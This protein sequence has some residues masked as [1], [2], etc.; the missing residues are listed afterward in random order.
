MIGMSAHSGRPRMWSSTSSPRQSRHHEVEDDEV[1]ALFPLEYLDRFLSVER[2]R[3][4]EGPLL[5][6]DLDDAANVSFVIGDKDMALFNRRLA[7][8][9]SG[10]KNR[11]YRLSMS[12]DI[13]QQHA[14]VGCRIGEHAEEGVVAHG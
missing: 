6:L 5:E 13:E 14:K 12:S 11:R 3:D 4:A 10:L 7:G 1:G 2:E 9:P 8:H